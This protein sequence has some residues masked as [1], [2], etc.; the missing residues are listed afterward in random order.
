M[1]FL[2]M[3]RKHKVV[4]RNLLCCILFLLNGKAFSQNEVTVHIDANSVFKTLRINDSLFFYQ[5]HVESG[6][7]QLATASGQT[8]TGT[9]KKYTVTEKYIIT[10]LERG[11]RVN[12]F[13][14]SLNVFPNKKFGG[15][16]FKER[17]YWEFKQIKSFLI[18]DADL[19]A[20]LEMEKKGREAIEYDYGIS[21]YNT[22]QL[23][24]R[25]QYDYNQL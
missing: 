3:I 7:Q 4:L 25:T 18:K 12:Y 17:P 21:K 24:I 9:S 13:I 19:L 22:N 15:L 16:K 6:V 20:F 23:I 1:P 11:Y 10:K 2:N 8:I 14:A 5:C